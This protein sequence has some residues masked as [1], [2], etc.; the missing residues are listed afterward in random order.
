MIRSMTAFAS[1]ELTLDGWL[2]SWEIRSVNHRYLDVA[3][4]LPDA[5]RFL[6]SET[7]T[8]IGTYLRRGRVECSLTWKKS[9]QDENRLLVHQ[10]YV[11]QLLK[12]AREIETLSGNSLAP[13]TA[14]EILK[15]PGALHE[16]ETDRE[17]WVPQILDLLITSLEQTIRVR[18]TEGRQLASLIEERCRRIKEQIAV[19]RLRIPEVLRCIRQKIQQR[20][21][22]LSANPDHE[23]LEQEMVYLTQ[24]LDVTEELDRLDTHIDEILRMMQQSEPVGRRLDFLVQELNRE[25]NTLGSKSADTETT[26]AAVEIKVFIEQIREQ[27]QNLE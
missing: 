23:R 12:A 20:L 11:K 22:E 7:R 19:T 13:F 2:F 10:N 17:R 15:W 5:F 1:A 26:R 27:T 18:E 6:E 24:K 8:R 4:R 16:P 25:A 14:L 3:I 9:E 21:V